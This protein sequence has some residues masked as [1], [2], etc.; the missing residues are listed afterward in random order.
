MN[1]LIAGRTCHFSWLGLILYLLLLTLLCSLGFWQLGRGEQKQALIRQQ[2]AV[3]Q[4][5]PLNLNQQAE[6]DVGNERYRRAR[7]NGRYDAVHQFLIDNQVMDGKSGFYVMTPLVVEGQ[8]K[9]IL[10]NRGWVAL[11]ADRQHLPDVSL[12]ARGIEVTG[13]INLFP[14]PGIKLA[15]MEQPGEGWPSVLQ[16]IDQGRIAEKL[17][18]GIADFQLELDADAGPG[19]RRDWRVAAVAIPPEKHQ[20]YAVQWFG[21]AIALSFLFIWISIRKPQ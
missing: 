6:L 14:T 19:Y 11:G 10:I 12:D 5:S 9:A 7:V 1:I 15:G 3:S 8:S 16:M 17:G 13:R 21:L 2:Q 18:Y 4:A 20:A